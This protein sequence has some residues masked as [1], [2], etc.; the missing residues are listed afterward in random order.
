MITLPSYKICYVWTLR[1]AAA[2]APSYYLC[3]SH[4][5]SLNVFSVPELLL[6]IP[7]NRSPI[8]VNVVEHKPEG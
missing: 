6:R 8:F 4:L 3:H 2:W 5:W 7:Q 1:I